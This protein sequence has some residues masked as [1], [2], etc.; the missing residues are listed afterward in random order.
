MQKHNLKV[1][2]ERM[3]D[4]RNTLKEIINLKNGIAPFDADDTNGDFGFNNHKNN[5]LPS[6]NVHNSRDGSVQSIGQ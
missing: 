5:E 3:D 6:L 4:F 2:R 1:S